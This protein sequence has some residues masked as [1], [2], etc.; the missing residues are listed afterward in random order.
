[1][2]RPRPSPGQ[3]RGSTQGPREH[4]VPGASG[5]AG[6]RAGERAS[7]RAGGQA[8]AKTVRPRCR[9][10]RFLPRPRPREPRPEPPPPDARLPHCL[11]RPRRESLPSTSHLR[12]SEP[13][14][15]SGRTTPLWGPRRGPPPQTHP[16]GNPRPQR[17]SGPAP[18]TRH[19]HRHTRDTHT[20]TPTRRGAASRPP[21][22]QLTHPHTFVPRPPHFPGGT[23]S[24]SLHSRS[25][26]EARKHSTSFSSAGPDRALA[27]I[28]PRQGNTHA[29]ARARSRPPQM[30]PSR[31]QTQTQTPTPAR[32]PA[33]SPA[34]R[35]GRRG[36]GAPPPPGP[37]GRWEGARRKRAPLLPEWAAAPGRCRRSGSSSPLHPLPPLSTCG[38][39]GQE[40]AAHGPGRATTVS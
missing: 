14:P 16:A 21:K 36:L 37:M 7:Q 25:D 24:P 1:M 9:P 18:A 30:L 22:S 27:A 31:P 32:P 11:P 35:P 39:P 15:R 26:S 17:R 3:A 34:H 19:T 12:G 23:R 8:G 33:R 29:H 5:E 6:G 20:R 4:G 28:S 40:E 38:G 10:A 2:S 13:R